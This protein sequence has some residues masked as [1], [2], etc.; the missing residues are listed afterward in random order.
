V[1]IIFDTNIFLAASK[2]GSLSFRI[3]EIVFGEDSGYFVYTSPALK[4]ELFEKLIIW[5]KKNLAGKEKIETLKFLVNNSIAEVIPKER[6]NIIKNDP[7][8]NKILECAIAA[9]ANL[10]ISMDKDL[11][12]LKQFR[13]IPIIHP[14]TF[15]HYFR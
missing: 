11:L 13:N 3:L 8:D 6:I 5:D 15:K 12:R 9:S 2:E 1:K 4:A 7:D 10:I 14:G